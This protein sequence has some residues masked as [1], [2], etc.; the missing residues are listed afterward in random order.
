MTGKPGKP[1]FPPLEE[2]RDIFQTVS[3][4]PPAGDRVA[5]HLQYVA[6]LLA[7]VGHLP[8]AAVLAWRDA[9]GAVRYVTI[10]R[11]LVVGRKTGE[12]GL[13]L[14][15]DDSLSRRHFSVRAAGAMVTLEDLG[16][17]NGTA[18]NTSEGRV[19]HATLCD[20]DLIYAGRHIFVYLNP[21]RTE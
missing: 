16:S 8:A 1:E 2:L 18:V 9:S 19:R 7:A 12:T 20:G 6:D 3:S 10:E 11:E 15:G 14:A 13:S 4:V 17:H 5:T 21:T